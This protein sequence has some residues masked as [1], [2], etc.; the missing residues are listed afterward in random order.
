[1]E[2]LPLEE[3]F[4]TGRK[5][6]AFR[7]KK[8]LSK[9]SLLVTDGLTSICS[10]CPGGNRISQ[11][12]RSIGL[13]HSTLLGDRSPHYGGGLPT[14]EKSSDPPA[15]GSVCVVSLP[16]YKVYPKSTLYPRIPHMRAFGT[17]EKIGQFVAGL[18]SCVHME[19]VGQSLRNI[20]RHP[21]HAPVIG[22]RP[23]HTDYATLEPERGPTAGCPLSPTRD[24]FSVILPHHALPL[25]PT[26][27]D[28]LVNPEGG[29]FDR[30]DA[31][32]CGDFVPNCGERGEV[33]WEQGLFSSQSLSPPHHLPFRAYSIEP[34]LSQAFSTKISHPALPPPQTMLFHCPRLNASLPTGC[35]PVKE[36]TD[37]LVGSVCSLNVVS[38]TER[39]I[40]D[41]PAETEREARER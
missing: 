2:V 28:G 26:C 20:V 12:V 25:E 19:G 4:G 16:E 13:P 5:S 32:V 38:I 31:D 18:S 11:W 24:L 15:V 37:F 41:K 34:C 10:Q 9:P 6:T 22:Q 29:R 40:R 27:Q 23:C 7:V 3:G 17:L 36:A 39:A 33:S 14:R 1:M 21:P 8:A 35:G 30:E